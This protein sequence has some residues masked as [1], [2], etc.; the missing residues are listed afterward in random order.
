MRVCNENKI[1]VP[2]SK[3]LQLRLENKIQQVQDTILKGVVKC[4]GCRASLL[5]IYFCGCVV[6]TFGLDSSES[7][8]QDSQE[9]IFN[10]ALHPNP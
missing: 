3:Q 6:G 10:Y 4:Q 9:K 1:F 5:L 8:N 7:Q 2:S